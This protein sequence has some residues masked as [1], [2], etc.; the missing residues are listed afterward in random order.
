MDINQ[1]SQEQLSQ[2]LSFANRLRIQEPSVG[3]QGLPDNQPGPISSTETMEQ[4]RSQLENILTQVQP[5]V[6]Q[7]S[8][9]I[10]SPFGARANPGI[11]QNPIQAYHSVHAPHGHPS[12]Q[13]TQ[14][15]AGLTGRL[16]SS[17]SQI[18]VGLYSLG[19]NRR[20]EVNYA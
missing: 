1:F 4:L 10:S 14:A 17:S 6:T 13:S 16:L 18:P 12:T 19:S 2:L 3:S 8:N 7:Q 15:T 20:G 11:A 9:N 5:H